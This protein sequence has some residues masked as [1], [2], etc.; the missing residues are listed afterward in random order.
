MEGNKEK[1]LEDLRGYTDE[2]YQN[3]NFGALNYLGGFYINPGGRLTIY[4]N[5]AGNIEFTRRL[6]KWRLELGLG[7]I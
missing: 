2:S 4:V 6:L 3:M 1:D 5:D 7:N